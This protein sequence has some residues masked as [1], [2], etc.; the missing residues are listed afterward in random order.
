[1]CAE[2]GSPRVTKV[3][4]GGPV[5]CGT[6]K[7]LEDAGAAAVRAFVTK[8][9]AP[10]AFAAADLAQLAPATRTAARTAEIAKALGEIAPALEPRAVRTSGVGVDPARDRHPEW[11]P[12]AFEPSGKLLVRSGKKVMRVDPETGEGEATDL[13]AWRDEVL[14]PDGKSRWLEA[15][16][17][18]EG[19]ALRAT[20][21]P[22]G[23]GDM[24]DVL[25]PIAPRLGKACAGGRG[26]PA[27][28]VPIAWGA[29][30]LEAVVAGQPVVLD[31]S[32]AEALPFLTED[33]APQGSPRSASGKAI[34]LPVTGGVL[35][36]RAGARWSLVRSPEL[37]PYAE[38]R[39]C[40][41]AE[42]AT[43]L[44]CLR[45]GKVTIASF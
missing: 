8:D 26:E 20:F 4:G 14:T 37:E 17:A 6:S 11:G 31:A 36:R 34:A 43:R 38:L 5:A 12:L 22:T 23:D 40:A 25:L 28:A 15:Y 21:A 13:P 18:C 32:H 9:D 29:R 1:M 19:V 27:L 42:D 16:H 7:P 10:R 30:G 3:H 39:H 24:N 35:V 33:P 2:G 44:A 41:I 45:R